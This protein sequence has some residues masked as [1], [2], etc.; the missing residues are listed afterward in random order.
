M[1]LPF[2]LSVVTL[3]WE[4]LVGMQAFVESRELALLPL[5]SRPFGF[6]RGCEIARQPPFAA[7]WVLPTSACA[8]IPGPEVLLTRKLYDTGAA[9]H[10]SIAIQTLH[11]GE[12]TL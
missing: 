4:P 1:C 10:S 8:R 2:L 11:S 3:C 6:S 7:V 9:P 12:R 5:H